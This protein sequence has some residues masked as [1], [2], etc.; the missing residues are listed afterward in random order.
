MMKLKLQYFGHLT[1]RTDSFEKTL[2]LGKIKGRRVRG[3]Q[4]MRWL[5]GLTN[6]MDMSLS[7]L[8][9]L[10]M[11]KGGLLCCCPWGHKESDMTE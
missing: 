2:M 3:Q 9:E 1:Q 6:S 5:D 10:V 4:R 11:D 8:R 7:K